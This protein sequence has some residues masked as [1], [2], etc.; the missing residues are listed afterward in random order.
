VLVE[1]WKLWI[2]V[3]FP[4]MVYFLFVYIHSRH[5]RLK[6]EWHAPRSFHTMKIFELKLRQHNNS[7]LVG[8]NKIL[9]FCV[10]NKWAVFTY[11]WIFISKM[12]PG[13]HIPIYLALVGSRYFFSLILQVIYIWMDVHVHVH[14]IMY[15]MYPIFFVL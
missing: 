7:L 6:W 11:S 10:V 15:H 9:V 13:I 12:N 8:S 2:E 3:H 1:G 4:F 14:I 5:I